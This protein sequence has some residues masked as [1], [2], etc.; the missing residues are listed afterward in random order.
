MGAT[1]AFLCVCAYLLDTFPLHAASA[2][3]AAYISFEAL[4]GFGF[5]LFSPE[6]YSALGY[7]WGNSILAFV[8]LVIGCSIPFF[9][10]KYGDKLPSSSS[11]ADHEN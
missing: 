9:L 7:G 11:Y 3:R 4:R 6:M 2:N 1:V 5:P 10:W 8:A